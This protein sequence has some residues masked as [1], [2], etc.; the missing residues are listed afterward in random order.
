[1]PYKD[2]VACPIVDIKYPFYAELEAYVTD[3]IMKEI[4]NVVDD[5]KLADA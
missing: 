5:A 4:R 2:A 3:G 1:M